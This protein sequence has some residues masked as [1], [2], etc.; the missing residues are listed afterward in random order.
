MTLVGLDAVSGIAR[1]S[2][3]VGWG[4]LR[5][6]LAPTGWSLQRSALYPAEATLGAL[7]EGRW[8]GA[9]PQHAGDL[10]Q[11]VVS[12]VATHGGERYE[13]TPAP[14]KSSGPDLRYLFIG[15]EG[16]VGRI[17]EVGLQLWPRVPGR[18][19]VAEVG[20]QAAGELVGELCGLGLRASWS[21]WEADVLEVAFHAPAALLGVYEAALVGAMGGRAQVLGWEREEA[22]RAEVEGAMWRGEVRWCARAEVGQVG[23]VGIAWDSH[24]ARIYGGEDVG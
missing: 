23:E 20:A 5:A 4:A 24:N 13:Y 16:G 7:L 9:S 1:V 14:R 10:R 8:G 11:S 17:E 6:L 3:D 15:G 18:L 2:A 12:L 21:W 22:R 19:L